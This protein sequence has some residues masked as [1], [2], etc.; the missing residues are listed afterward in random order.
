MGDLNVEDLYGIPYGCDVATGTRVA[1][2]T[3]MEGALFLAERGCVV[4]RL[5]MECT[6]VTASPTAAI[7]LYQFSGG[8]MNDGSDVAPRLFLLQA[9]AMSVGLLTLTISPQV[10][11]EEGFYFLTIGRDGG[12]SFT[13]R[14]HAGLANLTVWTNPGVAPAFPV[15]FSDPAA[16]SAPAATLNLAAVSSL[17]NNQAL[18]HRFL[19]V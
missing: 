5:I 16:P 9:Q 2:N 8:E 7:A 18:V 15:L 12:T 13:F 17:V 19:K 1:S 10:T 4:N 11:I 14:G 3:V 6:A